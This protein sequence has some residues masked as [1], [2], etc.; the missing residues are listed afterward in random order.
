MSQDKKTQLNKTLLWGGLT[1]TLYWALFHYAGDFQMLAHTTADACAVIE[2]GKTVYLNGATPELCGQRHGS[3]V[4]GKWW[5]VFAP[6][7]M[8]FALS[9]THGN[10][11][12]LFWDVLG[13]KAK[14]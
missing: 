13:L 12:A 8:A 10:F 11:T 3:F 14:K 4:E 9:Y 7:A 6:I 5:Y 2:G 1:A